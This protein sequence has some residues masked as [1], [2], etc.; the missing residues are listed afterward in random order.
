MQTKCSKRLNHSGSE[1]WKE[2]ELHPA[3]CPQGE[4][5]TVCGLG[6]FWENSILG[7]VLFC[8]QLSGMGR[9][10]EWSAWL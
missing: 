5:L 3:T 7:P 2:G 4:T 10:G 6:F 1:R 8:P 9:L